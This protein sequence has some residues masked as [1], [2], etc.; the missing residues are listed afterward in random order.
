MSQSLAL[1]VSLSGVEL[2]VAG[3]PMLH[4][5]LSSIVC[6]V[7]CCVACCGEFSI[8]CFVETWGHFQFTKKNVFRPKGAMSLAFS[9]PSGRLS[10]L[11]IVCNALVFKMCRVM[12]DRG[13]GVDQG[14]QLWQLGKT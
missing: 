5:A 1:L 11:M 2:R 3:R 12:L 10:D 8:I 9:W 4:T 6:C 7:D 14:T 13:V